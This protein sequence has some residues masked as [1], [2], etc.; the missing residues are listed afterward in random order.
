MKTIIAIVFLGKV[1][2]IEHFEPIIDG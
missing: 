2:M 1:F